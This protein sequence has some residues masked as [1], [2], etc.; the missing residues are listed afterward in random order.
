MYY[1]KYTLL[2]FF[3]TEFFPGKMS[4][5]FIKFLIKAEYNIFCLFIIYRIVKITMW[6][7]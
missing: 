5:F 7:F 1:M 2:L 6:E 4:I 3:K